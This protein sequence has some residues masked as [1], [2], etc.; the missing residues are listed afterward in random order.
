MLKIKSV[1]SGVIPTGFFQG[2]PAIILTSAQD[3]TPV[4]DSLDV[5]QKIIAVYY[6]EFNCEYFSIYITGDEPTVWDFSRLIN[7]INVD[8]RFAGV[9][10][11]PPHKPTRRKL[12]PTWIVRTNGTA[13]QPWLSDCEIA[14]APATTLQFVDSRVLAQA[15]SIEMLVDD[16]AYKLW[17]DVDVRLRRCAK[18]LI[19]P[20]IGND[21]E[22][23]DINI[24]NAM[25][26]VK[27][28]RGLRFQL[29]LS[30]Y[31]PGE[32]L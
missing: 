4:Q 8:F 14:L 24:K 11:N 15:V 6:D 32:K 29:D 3:D 1:K 25:D 30:N 2:Q 13:Y 23:Y 7:Y 17:N 21:I 19:P 12:E 9:T 20:L 18:Y 5:A 16:E 28:D 27:H 26:I 22:R 31:L 10:V